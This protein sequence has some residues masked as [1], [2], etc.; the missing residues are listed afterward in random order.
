MTIPNLT[1][2][3]DKINPGFKSTKA[4]LDAEDM[5]GIQALAAKQVE[6]GAAY[7]DVGIGPRGKSDPEILVKVIAAIQDAVDV[8]LCFDYTDA[9]ILE[10]CLKCYDESKAQGQMPMIN[11]IAETRWEMTELLRIRPCKVMLMVSERLEDGTGK[12]NKTA[13][14]MYSTA[15]RMALKLTGGDYGLTMDDI[16]IDVAISAMSSDTG[17]LTRA[18]IETVRQIGRDPELK[19]IHMSGGLTNLAG[20]LPKIEIDGAPLRVQLESA[21]LTLAMPHGFDMVLATPGRPYRILGEDSV[22]LHA[23]REIIALDGLDALRR[24]RKLYT[25]AKN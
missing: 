23:F 24:L 15:K 2:I 25:S 4:L 22:V 14:E 12:Q 16:I 1:I 17:G 5:A 13:D 20:Q 21:Y 7:L 19:G 3:G 10:T 18:S 11:S 6:A 8:P 9:E